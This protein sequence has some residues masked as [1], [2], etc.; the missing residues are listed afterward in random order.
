MGYRLNCL[1]E[2]VFIAVSKLLLSEFGIHYRS[3]SCVVYKRVSNHRSFNVE[4]I[5]AIEERDVWQNLPGTSGVV[6]DA[7][8]S[9]F[10]TRFF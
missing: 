2:P 7:V 4:W 8:F 6:I 10:N 5:A 3:E 1:T 9:G